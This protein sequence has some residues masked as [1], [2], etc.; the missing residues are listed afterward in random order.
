[1]ALIFLENVYTPSL[2]HFGCVKARLL[3]VWHECNNH[4]YLET[5]FLQICVRSIKYA[6]QDGIKHTW[7]DNK[8]RELVAVKVLHTS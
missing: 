5:I 3:H 2:E 7:T 1:V 8:V 6:S 4:S